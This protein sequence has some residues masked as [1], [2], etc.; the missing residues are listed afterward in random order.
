MV[1]NNVERKFTSA[2]SSRKL[3][4]GCQQHM[5]KNANAKCHLDPSK[6]ILSVIFEPIGYRSDDG[7]TSK[8][9]GIFCWCYVGNSG[10][11][12]QGFLFR[13]QL[14]FSSLKSNLRCKTGGLVYDW[15]VS[16]VAGLQSDCN[17]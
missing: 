14:I 4:T 9:K 8:G 7:Y 16:Q 5:L 12:G 11:T 6:R 15:S 1:A 13:V 3:L 2:S 17:Q 10:Y